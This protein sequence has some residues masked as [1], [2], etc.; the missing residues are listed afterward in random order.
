MMCKSYIIYNNIFQTGQ[1]PEQWKLETG[2]PI[3][4][5]QNKLENEDSLRVISLTNNFSKILERIIMKRLLEHIGDKIDMRQFGGV[6]NTSTTHY[7]IEFLSFILFNLDNSEAHAVLSTMIDFSKAF[8]RIDHNIIISK[9]ADL[10]V[11]PWILKVLIGFLSKRT[12]QVKYRGKLSKIMEMPGGGPQGTII[13]MF[14]FIILINPVNFGP[15]INWGK[16]LS[17]RKYNELKNIHLKYIDDLTLAEAIKLKNLQTDTRELEFPVNFHQRTGHTLPE[18]MF[19]SQ[20]KVK[21]IV[22]YANTNGM[23]INSTKSKVMIFNRSKK[24]DFMPEIEFSEGQV[25]EVVEEMKLLGVHITSNLKWHTHVANICKRAN[26]KLWLLRRLKKL[27]AD[28]EI[29]LDLYN[30]QIRSIVEYALPVWGPGITKHDCNQIERIQKCA[31]A[32]IFGYIDYDIVLAKYGLK[33][34]EERRL[35]AVTKF[36]LK[37]SKHPVF[38]KWFNLKSSKIKTRSKAIYSEIPFRTNQWGNS[39]IPMMT[40]LLNKRNG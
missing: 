7:L 29:L 19:K 4:K 21:E 8:N 22:D 36:A 5:C 14:L 26:T 15:S 23:K 25:G 11:P 24:F 20:T 28:N 10:N 39:P 30:K 33:S 1:W 12:L 31:Y 38:S 18:S 32:I 27:G 40:R 34:L 9:L 35:E 13:G 6:K 2:I 16:A 17:S 3:P 37:S